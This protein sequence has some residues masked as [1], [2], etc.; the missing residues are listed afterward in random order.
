MAQTPPLEDL[1]DFP[2]A[3]T[4]R[5]VAKASAE[6]EGQ[7]R[8]IVEHSLQRPLLQIGAQE[9]SGGKFLSVRATVTVV[10][11]DEIR[12]TYEALQSVEHLK[13]LL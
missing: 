13:M 10:N 12:V 4:F 5:V 7:V 6:L 3:F 1:V 9:S 2:T 11:A 8:E